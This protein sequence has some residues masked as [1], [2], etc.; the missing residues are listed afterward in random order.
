MTEERPEQDATD[1]TDATDEPT[2]A[3]EA[4]AVPEAEPQ[5]PTDV[6]AAPEGAAASDEAVEAVA[7][8][9]PDEDVEH[10][11]VAAA[12]TPSGKTSRHSARRVLAALFWLLASV[13]VLAAGLTV[14][15]HQTLLTSD[16]WG[17]LVGEVIA[18]E[19][20]VDA[21]SVVVV[22][23][24]SESTGLREIVADAIPG[25]DIIAGAVTATVENQIVK[26]V[27]AFAGSDAFQDAFVRVNEDAYDAALAVIR[28]GDSEALTSEDGLISLN[29]FPLIEGVLHSL[30]D[31]GIIDESREIP[32]LTG[33]EASPQLI[34][35]L[36]TLLGRDIPDDV[37]TIVLVD[38]ENLES[39]QTF[40]RWFDL[41]TVGG[42]VLFA[43]FTA[44]ALWLSQRRIRMVQWLAGGAIAALLTGRVVVR[45]A[46]EAV[47]QRQEEAEA[48]VVVSAIVDAAVDSFMWFT[49]VLM[50]VALIIGIAAIIWERR[51]TAERGSEAS[52]PRTLG[53]WIA[54]NVG[55]ILAIGVGLIG[56]MA[57]W[58]IGGPGV[59]MITAAALMLLFIAVQVLSD[60]SDGGSSESTE[61]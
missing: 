24:L 37:G 19:E 51:G 10:D 41:I 27:E 4:D 18:E 52:Q 11:V 13:S 7:E 44:L 56:V 34:S 48:R 8:P 14:W 59:A 47:T 40:V 20:V 12:A 1:A 53:Q 49:F 22:D 25:P 36:E 61:G 23:R 21:I 43:F 16:G 42:L 26:A 2:A 57:L 17:G 29:I 38:S 30:Q 58:S 15:T 60:Q 9:A 50:A 28:G 45:L 31:A 46:L 54:D 3:P 32:D 39:V 6:A 35:T 33:Y 55:I 5:E